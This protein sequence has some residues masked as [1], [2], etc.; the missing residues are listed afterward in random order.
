MQKRRDVAVESRLDEA[1]AVKARVA[2]ELPEV[3]EIRDHQLREKV[4]EAWAL[5]LSHSSFSSIREIPPAGNPGVLVL[6]KGD[7]TDHIRG[8]TRL[9]MAIADELATAYPELKIDRDIVVAGGLCHDIGKP[10][11]FDPE[12]QKR[13]NE[14][15]RKAGRPSIRHPAYG[16]HICLTVGLSEEIAHIAAAHSGEGE[17]LVRSLENTIINFADHAFWAVLTSGGLVDPETIPPKQRK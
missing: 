6:T 4:V 1:T 9:A 12:N 3:A 2:E 10:W 14:S 7:Q 13:W 16:A 5:A 11:E 8:V 15:P 17:L